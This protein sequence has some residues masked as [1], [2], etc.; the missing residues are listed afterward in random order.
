[1]QLQYLRLGQEIDVKISLTYIFNKLLGSHPWTKVEIKII[2]AN[3]NEI[4]G[5]KDM[6]E[7]I[8]AINYNEVVFFEIKRFPYHMIAAAG[9]EENG[10]VIVY[11][12]IE[13]CECE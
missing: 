10:Q 8:K 6:P 7:V 13:K 1:M 4:D 9:S 3:P 12:E 2:D 5:I 11:G